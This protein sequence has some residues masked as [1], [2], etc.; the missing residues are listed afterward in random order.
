MIYFM[1]DI[2]GK[3]DKVIDT[4]QRDRPQAIVLLGDMECE[5]PLHIILAP[6]RNLT[7][8][9]WIPGNHD[10]DRPEL[11]ANLVESELADRNLHGRVQQIDGVKV[12]G[13]G[14]V[15]R[16]EVWLPPH[17]PNFASHPDYE[18]ARLP[19]RRS[20]AEQGE[21]GKRLKHQSSLFP[22]V[23]AGLRRQRA[24]I[25]VTHEAPSCHPHGFGAID[26]LAKAMRVTKMFHGH[27]HD[28]LDYSAW[29]RQQ[30]IQA[31]GVGM[32]GITTVDGVVVVPG[33]RDDVRRRLRQQQA[34]KPP[35]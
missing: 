28:C 16:Q 13:L 18:K 7:E 19:P 33:E 15:F 12:A 30:G 8:I 32:R 23:Y 25:L 14:G 6:I 29:S 27:Q 20:R 9:W 24:E 2:H 35:E 4:V 3:F 11:W 26:E 34:G 22:D 17:P 10:V 1:G 21:G 5:Q 31:F